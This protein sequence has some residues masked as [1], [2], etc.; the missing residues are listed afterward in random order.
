MY[1]W[2]INPGMQGRLWLKN[3][4][5]RVGA[6]CRGIVGRGVSWTLEASKDWSEGL[7]RDH[8]QVRVMAANEVDSILSQQGPS[9][10]R[11][12]A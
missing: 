9:E 1:L 7:T 11:E 5:Y 2:P 6:S 3:K 8:R 12:P 4:G 10:N